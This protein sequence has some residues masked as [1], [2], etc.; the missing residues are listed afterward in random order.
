MLSMGLLFMATG[1][2]E[3]DNG[4]KAIA[5]EQRYFDLYMG[6]TFR[7]TIAPPT[8]SGL[9]YIEVTQGTGEMP[10]EDDW[11][12]L[13]Y[14]GTV[15]PEEQVVDSYLENV[16]SD[17]NLDPNHE[18]MYGSFKL[19][20]GTRTDGLTEGLS[21]MREGGEAIMCFTSDL[22][23]GS[24][25]TTTLMK[26][27]RSYKSMKY[28]VQLL[29]VIPD[30]EAYEQSRIEAYTDTIM[31]VETIYDTI[32]EATMYYVVDLPNDTGSTIAVDSVVEIAYKGYLIDGR[33]FD[34]SA[35]GE[36][37]EFTVGEESGVIEGWNLGV[38]RFREGEKGRL[39]I[40]YPLAY[41]EL[42]RMSQNIVAIPP[43]ETL[44][45]DIEIVSV[46][47][48]SDSGDTGEK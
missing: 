12:L 46:N 28:E 19:Q 40:S 32:T 18:A 33:V 26:S 14:V 2:K 16:A 6:V 30:M 36:P 29:E 35:E 3:E 24:T 45:F 13:N 47:S 5:Q 44:V 10:D 8:E 17:H 37:F 31:G 21:M 43:Y 34:E 20:N 1:C 15:I 11:M 41:G 7:D 38:T 23:Y 39:I 42:G 22:G 9:F 4:E 27:V 48:G 25:G